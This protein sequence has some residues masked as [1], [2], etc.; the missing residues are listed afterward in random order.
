[1]REF[2]G[3]KNAKNGF[4]TSDRD[5]YVKHGTP[6][7]AKN[8]QKSSFFTPLKNTVKP[9]FSAKK[10]GQKRPFFGNLLLQTLKFVSLGPQK[11]WPFS[12]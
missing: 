10:G 12:R 2:R 7:V 8:R 11:K 3:P 4:F 9:R 1:M 5:I 6:K